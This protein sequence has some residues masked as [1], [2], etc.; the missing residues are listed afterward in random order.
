MGKVPL[1]HPISVSFVFD[2]LRVNLTAHQRDDVAKALFLLAD[3]P[4]A[5]GLT[6]EINSGAAKIEEGLDTFI[7]KGET[8]FRG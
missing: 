6:I 8:D 5:A 1:G 7:K 3:R 2:R 4:D